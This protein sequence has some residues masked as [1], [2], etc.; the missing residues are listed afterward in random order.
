MVELQEIRF[1]KKH[2]NVTAELCPD[3]KRGSETTKCAGCKCQPSG[4]TKGESM[5]ESK[6]GRN[7]AYAKFGERKGGHVHCQTGQ[8]WLACM[9]ESHEK[10]VRTGREEW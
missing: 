8:T 9:L 1:R 3:G 4:G 2:K 6:R 5:S 7:T 10:A